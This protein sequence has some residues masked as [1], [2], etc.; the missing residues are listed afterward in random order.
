MPCVAWYARQVDSEAL[1]GHLDLLLLAA[2]RRE[3]GY[4]YAVLSRM[5]EMSGGEIDVPEGT[6]YPALHRLQRRGLLKSSWEVVNGRRRRVYRIT[7]RGEREFVG[8]RQA[9][10]RF[11]AGIS[12]S[13]E[14]SG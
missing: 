7:A 8:R 12:R 4:G 3:P 9:W 14:S 1:K 13:L 2:L 5:R 6:V 11:S 10:E